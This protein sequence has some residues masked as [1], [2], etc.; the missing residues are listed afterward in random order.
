MKIVTDTRWSC[1]FGICCIAYRYEEEE[2][3]RMGREGEG[4]RRLE[5]AECK[6][7]E[8]YNGERRKTGERE[9]VRER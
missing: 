1:W 4:V 5:E 9:E 7:E 3:E 6:E 2:G 8:G